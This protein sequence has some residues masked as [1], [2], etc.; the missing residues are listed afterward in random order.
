MFSIIIN[1]R[2]YQLLL[3]S[4]TLYLPPFVNLIDVLLAQTNDSIAKRDWYISTILK[5]K[6][7]V[8][9]WLLHFILVIKMSKD[10]KHGDAIL[11]GPQGQS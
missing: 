10:K 3:L 9:D 4:K 6:T 1:L 8:V 5:I 11:N 7:R 2:E